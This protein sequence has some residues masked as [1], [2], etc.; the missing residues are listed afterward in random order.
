MNKK[1]NDY[2]R[3]FVEGFIKASNMYI[4]FV[5]F[6]P[7]KQYDRAMDVI[8]RYYKRKGDE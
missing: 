7:V 2:E 6:F 8:E 4:K 1:M 3:G 5:E